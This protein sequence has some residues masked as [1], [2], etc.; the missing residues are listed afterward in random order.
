M[1]RAAQPAWYE[2]KV[3]D[4]VDLKQPGLYEWRIES[5]GV[6]IGQYTRGRRPNREY[7]LN[8]ARLAACQPYR[9]AKPDGFRHIHRALADAVNRGLPI[10]RTL[11]EN[12]TSKELRNA[13]EQ[14][15]IAERR[16]EATKGGL[17]VLND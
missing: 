3:N 13:R 4:G 2:R 12:Q 1:P 8:V 6:Y 11:L 15:L 7:A 17:P 9:K 5:V 16:I 10:T 14:V